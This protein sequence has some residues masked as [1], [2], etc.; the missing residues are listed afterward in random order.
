MAAE[1]EAQL[2][3]E[4]EEERQRR[5]AARRRQVLSELEKY[6]ALI[7]QTIQRNWNVDD[8]M[9]GKSCELTISLAPSGFVKSVTTGA[10]DPAVCRSAE[11]A[12]L[13]ATTLPVSEDPEVYQQMST[14]KLTVKPQL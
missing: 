1:R 8:S 5:S 7:Q 3:K 10:G 14:I 11:N 12:V 6:Q 4:M 13:K 9:S 2:Q